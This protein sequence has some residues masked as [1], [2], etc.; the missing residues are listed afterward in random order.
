MWSTAILLSW[1]Q[2]CQMCCSEPSAITPCWKSRKPH[3]QAQGYVLTHS[4]EYPSISNHRLFLFLPVQGLSTDDWA[5]GKRCSIRGCMDSSGQT[6][7]LLSSAKHICTP[8]HTH[9]IN[10]KPPA[11]ESVFLITLRTAG[12]GDGPGV[13]VLCSGLLTSITGKQQ[14]YS[15]E[16]VECGGLSYFFVVVVVFFNRAI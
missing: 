9:T 5:A 3:R 2:F 10:V 8:T 6:G 13:L 1:S 15:W 11:L 7:R 4:I 16:S 14:I 12:L